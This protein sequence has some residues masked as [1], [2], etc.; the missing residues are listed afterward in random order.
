MSPLCMSD[1]GSGQRRAADLHDGVVFVARAAP[2]LRQPLLVAVRPMAANPRS[3][4]SRAAEAQQVRPIASGCRGGTPGVPSSKRESRL[5]RAPG[6][7][8]GAY[9]VSHCAQAGGV[10]AVPIGHA[11]YL[12][13]DRWGSVG[14]KYLGVSTAST[15]SGC[16][17]HAYARISPFGPRPGTAVGAPPVGHSGTSHRR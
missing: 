13:T 12:C 8:G 9:P 2:A 10:P 17:T 15:P 4:R 1:G 6:S 7:R 3:R 5:G 16:I 14:R 11:P